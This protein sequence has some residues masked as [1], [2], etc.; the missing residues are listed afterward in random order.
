MKSASPATASSSDLD[1]AASPSFA[2][3]PASFGVVSAAVAACCGP[4]AAAALLLPL[5]ATNLAS[6]AAPCGRK[7][8]WG[9]GG[10]GAEPLPTLISGD[11]SGL[12]RWSVIYGQRNHCRKTDK[13][14][15]KDASRLQYRREM[16][17]QA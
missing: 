2:A 9:T 14:S 16:V 5:V 11:G 13:Q 7:A 3:A 6:T 4:S 8:F 12:L 17:Q 15:I 1:A 10:T